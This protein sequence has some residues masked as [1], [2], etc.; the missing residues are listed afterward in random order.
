[1]VQDPG[2]GFFRGSGSIKALAEC[3]EKGSENWRPVKIGPSQALFSARPITRTG[4]LRY[5]NKLI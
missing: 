4:Q 1:M 3:F 5:Q 2:S